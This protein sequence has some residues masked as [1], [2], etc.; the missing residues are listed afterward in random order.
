M[1]IK[2]F[3]II[4]I[5]CLSFIFTIMIFEFMV[6]CGERTYFEDGHWLTNECLF[7]PHDQ[8]SGRWK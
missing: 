1:M 5:I 7:I 2:T 4:L 3:G 8:I 6:G